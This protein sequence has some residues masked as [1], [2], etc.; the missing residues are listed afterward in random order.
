MALADKISA[1][2]DSVR[3]L[4]DVSFTDSDLPDAVLDLPIYK[5]AALAYVGVRTGNEDTFAIIAVY[6]RMAYLAIPSIKQLLSESNAGY[7]Y[8][9]K[10]RDWDARAE[11]LCALAD[12]AILDS[13]HGDPS[14]IGE[15]FDVAAT[16]GQFSVAPAC[17]RWWD[18]P[19]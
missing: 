16:I 15:A 17:T 19:C 14:E 6:Y 7:T 4:I 11:E 12:G 3:K 9:I 2:Y 1:P 18:P 10:S 5:D 13:E 8:S